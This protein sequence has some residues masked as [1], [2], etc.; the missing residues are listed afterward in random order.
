MARRPGNTLEKWEVALVK[1]MLARKYVPQDIQ[2]Y[3]SRPTRSINHAR[4]SEIRDGTKHKAIKPAIDEELDTFLDAWPNID[5][6]TDLHL[7]GDELLIKAREAMIAAVHTFNSAGLYFRAELFIVTAII[8]WTYLMHTYY[9]REGVD[10]RHKKG[11][12]VERTPSG[13]EKYWELSQCITTGACPLET[14]VVNNLKFLIEIRNEIQHRSTNRI[15]DALSAKLQACCINFNDAIKALFGREFALEKRLP[16]ALQFVTFDGVQR[17]SLIATDLPPH[18]ATAMDNF[19]AA[20][21]E[22]EQK[23]PKFRFRVAFVPKLT[24]KPSKAN[25]AVE[26]IKPGSPE[27]E[28]VERVLLKDVE[29]PKFLPS[30][31]VAKVKATGHAAFNMYDHTKLSEQLDARNPGKGYGVKV[32]N[33]WYWYE[34]WL[35]KVLEKLNEGWKR[36]GK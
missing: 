33:T 11:G 3:F 16:I 36:P 30:D 21:T 10:Y 1:A 27:A 19:H 4:I 35:E 17:Q 31:I 6:N 34:N 23:D 12:V 14:G 22:D 20:L 29:R 32:A 28:A 18:I 7:Q 24:S 5:P 2:A 13:A 8:A 9:K 15:D 25:L 26:F